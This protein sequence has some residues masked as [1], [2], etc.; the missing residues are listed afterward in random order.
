[1]NRCIFAA[2]A[3]VGLATIAPVTAQAQTRS[4]DQLATQEDDNFRWYEP[5]AADQ[6]LPLPPGP[7][8]T[9]NT[10]V[11]PP[12]NVPP[13]TVHAGVGVALRTFFAGLPTGQATEIFGRMTFGTSQIVGAELGLLLPDLRP[14]IGLYIGVPI[15]PRLAT[16]SDMLQIQLILPAFRLGF[17]P[18]LPPRSSQLP[19]FLIAPELIPI[20]VRLTSCGR[21]FVEARLDGPGAWVTVGPVTNFTFG[22]G[23]SIVI[24]G[25]FGAGP[26]TMPPSTPAPVQ[27]S[28]RDAGPRGCR[29]SYL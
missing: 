18:L 20:G 26:P 2:L 11:I 29:G 3:T 25:G 9:V 1:M 19:V 7:P 5:T 24:G 15:A 17:A 4:S 12:E 28:A 14:K 10:V 21:F 8:A 6:Q 22:F 13:P 27:A 16:I 23:A